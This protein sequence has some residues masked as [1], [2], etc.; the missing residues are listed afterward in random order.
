MA[1][2]LLKGS[3]D[4]ATQATN[5]LVF[6]TACTRLV[7]VRIVGHRDAALNNTIGTCGSWKN[8]TRRYVITLDTGRL[9]QINPNQLQVVSGSR[10]HCAQCPM[11]I[12]PSLSLEGK[13]AYQNP[14]YRRLIYCCGRALCSNCDPAVTTTFTDV[15]I[16]VPIKCVMCSSSGKKGKTSSQSKAATAPV[17]MPPIVCGTKEELK[18]LKKLAKKHQAWA[19]VILGYRYSTGGPGV[20]V[21]HESSLYHFEVAAKKGHAEGLYNAGCGYFYGK[22][23]SVDM[24][25]AL[26]YLK[27]AAQEDHDKAMSFLARMYEEGLGCESRSLEKATEM[28][29]RAAGEEIRLPCFFSLEADSVEDLC[30]DFERTKVEL[31]IMEDD[32]ESGSEEEEEIREKQRKNKRR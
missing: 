5:R 8:D 13:N 14:Y 29:R 15:S 28:Y 12:P 18:K 25:K 10:E 2:F 19:H 6:S 22:G 30:C 24:L 3:N 27:L 17:M 21:S 7:R 32:E 20:K 26:E 31:E 9:V 4:D 1:N 11:L 16:D 23:C